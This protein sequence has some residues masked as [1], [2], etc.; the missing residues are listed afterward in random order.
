MTD[1]RISELMS[2]DDTSK[3]LGL[4]RSSVH[5]RIKNGR[6]RSARLGIMWFVYKNSVEEYKEREDGN[7]G[8]GK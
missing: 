7:L 6:L 8:D 5:W 2:I 4:S 1:P 3:A